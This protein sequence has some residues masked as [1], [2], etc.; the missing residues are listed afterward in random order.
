[1]TNIKQISTMV[2]TT[3][4]FAL[5]ACG[6]STVKDS[7]KSAGAAAVD[8]AAKVEMPKMPGMNMDFMAEM[9][10]DHAILAKLDMSKVSDFSEDCQKMI[11]KFGDMKTKMAENPG[12]DM[13]GMMAKKMAEMKA[14]GP[15]EM[16][17]MM[18]KH[19]SCIVEIK[20][21]LPA[22]H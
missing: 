13:A 16:K 21:T 3:A 9:K 12:T 18:T 17:A 15:A 2:L 7:V 8:Q 6:N 22:E 11:G 5:T 20:A 10:K 19:K 14:K 1:M 4:M